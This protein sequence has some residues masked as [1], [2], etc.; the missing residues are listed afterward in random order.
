VAR[1]LAVVLALAEVAQLHLQHRDVVTRVAEPE[2]APIAGVGRG[3][4]PGTA[5]GIHGRP[6]VGRLRPGRG[7][8]LAL[9]EPDGSGVARRLLELEDGTGV[10][11]DR[12]RV[13]GGRRGMRRRGAL[14]FGSGTHS[15]MPRE[16]H[17]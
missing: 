4:R 5:A 6:G 16:R 15:I 11:R 1:R 10:E 8:R 9:D 13:A 17:A 12:E 2:R 14:A 3:R 7:H